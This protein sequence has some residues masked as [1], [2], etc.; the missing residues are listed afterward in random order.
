ML[1]PLVSDTDLVSRLDA[2]F[3]DVRADL[4]LYATPT[5]YVSYDTVDAAGR[6]ELARVVDALSEPLSQLSSS[7]VA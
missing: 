5:G 2:A 6:R 7:A 3:A 1:R 4:L